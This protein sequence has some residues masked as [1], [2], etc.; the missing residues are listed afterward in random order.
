LP[1]FD[2]ELQRHFSILRQDNFSDTLVECHCPDTSEISS[3]QVHSSML[4]VSSRVFSAAL[5]LVKIRSSDTL[6]WTLDLPY[7]NARSDKYKHMVDMLQIVSEASSPV[8]FE[9]IYNKPK[10]NLVIDGLK[11]EVI[12][13]LFHVFYNEDWDIDIK[14]LAQFISLL[15][16]LNCYGIEQIKELIHGAASKS[17]NYSYNQDLVTVLN[18]NCERSAVPTDRSLGLKL[19]ADLFL[20]SESVQVAE[21]A[22]QDFEITSLIFFQVAK[23][24]RLTETFD[25]VNCMDFHDLLLCGK[26]ACKLLSCRIETTKEIRDLGNLRIMHI[27]ECFLFKTDDFSAK[28]EIMRS[29]LKLKYRLLRLGF[30]LSLNIDSSLSKYFN[31]PRKKSRKEP[32]ISMV[33]EHIEMITS[34]FG[35]PITITLEGLVH[36]FEKV[37]LDRP[38]EANK[39]TK[40]VPS[41]QKKSSKS[42]EPISKDKHQEDT[43]FNLKKCRMDQK[44]KS[45]PPPAVS[46]RVVTSSVPR[47]VHWKK[48]RLS[49]FEE[50]PSSSKPDDRNNNVVLDVVHRYHKNENKVTRDVKSAPRHGLAVGSVDLDNLTKDYSEVKDSQENRAE[51]SFRTG[52]ADVYP[53]GL[54]PA[55]NVNVFQFYKTIYL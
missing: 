1:H 12:K 54:F 4:A 15:R 32:S 50:R 39:D 38:D 49:T 25:Y 16:H 48:R 34:G 29:R 2:F 33:L 43:N 41:K 19:L 51:E 27:K 21:C 42:V 37:Y 3:F 40:N 17:S 13:S 45:F 26:F 20:V 7:S 44:S 31:F 36:L 8:H 46:T 22:I 10:F 18:I 47:Q 52:T 9:L 35:M 11:F 14:S 55:S 30:V 6:R 24:V 53:C 28:V 5:A 23:T